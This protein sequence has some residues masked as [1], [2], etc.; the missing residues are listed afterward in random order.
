ML[1]FD[2]LGETLTDIARSY[3]RSP[4]HDFAAYGVKVGMVMKWSVK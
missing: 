2:D 4:E 1:H 3:N